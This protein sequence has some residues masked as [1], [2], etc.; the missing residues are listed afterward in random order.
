MSE[1]E[2]QQHPLRGPWESNQPAKARTSEHAVG[3]KRQRDKA[4]LLK[5]T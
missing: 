2:P 3:I 4:L 5:M 1:T